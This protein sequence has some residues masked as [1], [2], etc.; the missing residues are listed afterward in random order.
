MSRFGQSV[1]LEAKYP[2][3]A[4]VMERAFQKAVRPINVEI[5]KLNHRN[6]VF[7]DTLKNL[8]CEERSLCQ[9]KKGCNTETSTAEFQP[10]IDKVNSKIARVKGKI[11]KNRSA[12]SELRLK[13]SALKEKFEEALVLELEKRECPE[14]AE[15]LKLRSMSF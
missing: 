10:K 8:E 13:K 4:A 1:F 2:L 12:L 7:Y 15:H 6:D 3:E 14:L 9:K 11:D 5:E